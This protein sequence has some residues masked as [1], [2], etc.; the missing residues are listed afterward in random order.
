MEKIRVSSSVLAFLAGM[1]YGAFVIGILWF[2]TS[3]FGAPR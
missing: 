3:M 1:A 2:V